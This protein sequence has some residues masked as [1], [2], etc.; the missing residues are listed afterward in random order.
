MD[1]IQTEPVCKSEYTSCSEIVLWLRFFIADQIARGG[2]LASP[3]ALSTFQGT[4]T[5]SGA[6]AVG[7]MI[8]KETLLT[9]TLKNIWTK[10][11]K[12]RK[13]LKKRRKYQYRVF[14]I[15]I[16]W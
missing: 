8:S 3:C 10:N 6:G 15:S 11:Y 14:Q 7:R 12:K 5:G 1:Y 13:S 16:Y 2:A 9:E 4:G